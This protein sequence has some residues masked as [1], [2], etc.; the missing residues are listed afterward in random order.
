M[1]NPHRLVARVSE[2]LLTRTPADGGKPELASDQR[3][4]GAHLKPFQL[5]PFRRPTTACCENGFTGAIDKRV[6]LFAHNGDLHGIDRAPGLRLGRYLP[7]GIVIRLC[8][9]R[10]MESATKPSRLEYGQGESGCQL[11]RE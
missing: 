8:D 10:D 4:G 5:P 1:T 11:P 2:P 7:I 9:F 3:P 6:H